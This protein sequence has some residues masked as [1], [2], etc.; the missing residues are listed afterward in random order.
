MGTINGINVLFHANLVSGGCLC[1]FFFPALGRYAFVVGFW[2]MSSMA[3]EQ[4]FNL[5]GT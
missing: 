3:L 1:L 5:I 4:L 2:S